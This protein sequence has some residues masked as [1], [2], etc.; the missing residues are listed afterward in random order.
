LSLGSAEPAAFELDDPALGVRLRRG[1]QGRHVDRVGAR[2][3]EVAHP[4]VVVEQLALG[5]HDLQHPLVDT[6]LGEEP[7]D[8][9]RPRLAEAVEPGDGLVLDRRLPLGL[10]EHD[11]RR[12]LDVEAHPTGLDLAHQHRRLR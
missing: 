12:R 1:G 7:M 4:Y 3:L 5:G 6:A 10:G 8:V 2:L 11:H 9:D